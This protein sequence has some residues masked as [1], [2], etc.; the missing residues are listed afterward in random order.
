MFGDEIS[1]YWYDIPGV[2]ILPLRLLL[3]GINSSVLK[4]G[5]SSCAYSS[6]TPDEN[7][8]CTR[9]IARRLIIIDVATPPPTR[10]TATAATVPIMTGRKEP[11]P[12]VD[13][14]DGVSL[15]FAEL[16]GL[17]DRVFSCAV[18]WRVELVDTALSVEI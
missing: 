2:P 17:E 5:L 10:T 16:V 14:K 7:L 18:V 9:I 13:G 11:A 15:G 6:A 1:F 3:E 12:V 4:S 8:L